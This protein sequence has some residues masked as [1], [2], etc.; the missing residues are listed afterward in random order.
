MH[1]VCPAWS[2]YRMRDKGLRK[3]L[4]LSLWP[5]RQGQIHR[6]YGQ[7]HLQVCSV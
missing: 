5:T 6:E 1:P 7:R 2:H 3:D 4:P